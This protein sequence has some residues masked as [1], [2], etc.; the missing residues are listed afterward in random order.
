MSGSEADYYESNSSEMVLNFTMHQ[1]KTLAVIKHV[2]GSI[3]L[4][5]SA[6]LM[7]MICRSYSGLS[8]PFHRLLFGLCFFDIIASI[9]YALST[10]MSP[11]E[12]SYYV[13]NASGNMASCNFQGFLHILGNYGCLYNVSLC[14]Y[15]LAVIKYSMSDEDIRKKI[16]PF[17][18]GV[19]IICSIVFAISGLAVSVYNAG[20]MSGTCLPTIYAPPHCLGR[21]YLQ[22]PEGYNIPCYRGL[23][24]AR[25]FGA[26][27]FVP[28]FIAAPLS[29]IVFMT[30]VYRSVLRKERKMNQYGKSALHIPRGKKDLGRLGYMRKLTSS[31]LKKKK[32]KQLH[33][34]VIFY[35][36]LWYSGAFFLSYSMSITITCA[37]YYFGFKMPFW[38]FLARDIFMPLQGF[39]NL[40]IY[41]LPRV[42]AAKR[43]KKEPCTWLQATIKTFWSRGAVPKGARGRKSASNDKSLRRLRT[44]SLSN[45]KK[46]E[47]I[48]H[49]ESEEGKCATQASMTTLSK[50]L[51]N[52]AHHNTAIDI[53]KSILEQKDASFV[54]LRSKQYMNIPLP[55]TS[56]DNTH[57]TADYRNNAESD[58]DVSRVKGINAN[59][60]TRPTNISASEDSE[61]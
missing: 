34:R 28:A 32:K 10:S 23:H 47:M 11:K 8:T 26:V 57:H 52:T 4:F 31:S 53:E 46:L 6:T 59:D 25:I 12:T 3:S 61:V 9:G 2:C 43:S 55:Q 49:N 42:K 14:A 40:L 44:G 48:E 24:S 1:I 22:I 30:L 5:A 38:S 51:R 17:L 37:Y 39:Y 18:H 45:Q 35:K 16:E 58:S 60:E 19:P 36:G 13:W 21:D 54:K 27:T 41:F 56:H 7:W 29:I 50:P 15:Y 33:S 20:P